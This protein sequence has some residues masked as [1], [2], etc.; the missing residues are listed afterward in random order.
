MNVYLSK[1]ES[2]SILDLFKFSS[3]QEP[4]ELD[5]MVTFAYIFFWPLKDNHKSRKIFLLFI[6]LNLVH[7]I[8]KNNRPSPIT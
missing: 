4:L 5:E 2:Y 8:I 3:F 7:Y 6:K 1:A